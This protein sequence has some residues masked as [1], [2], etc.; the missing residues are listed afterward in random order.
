MA[1][2]AVPIFEARRI[3]RA[4]LV[5]HLKATVQFKRALSTGNGQAGGPSYFG[6]RCK[7]LDGQ[8]FY[9]RINR[10]WEIGKAARRFQYGVAW[11]PMVASCCRLMM[12]VMG[13]R[14][15]GGKSS[16]TWDRLPV[17][18]TRFDDCRSAPLCFCVRRSHVCS[19][20]PC[21]INHHSQ[22]PCAHIIYPCVHTSIRTHT[23]ARTHNHT[24]TPTH[25][26][27]RIYIYVTTRTFT[28]IIKTIIY[29]HVSA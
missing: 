15:D 7:G 13:M 29:T 22:A 17:V 28:R 16:R 1:C 2:A 25:T 11:H 21:L 6:R 5:P 14:D 27:A 18:L 12:S 23:D 19:Q 26:H 8:L 10:K 20:P 4:L 24:H 9:E 3:T